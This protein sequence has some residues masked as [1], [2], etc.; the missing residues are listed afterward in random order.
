MRRRGVCPTVSMPASST[1]AVVVLATVALL[2]APEQSAPAGPDRLELV[3]T[4]TPIDLVSPVQRVVVL[5]AAGQ[6]LSTPSKGAPEFRA[7]LLL[8]GH[9]PA[10]A[11]LP[12]V[13]AT[14][15]AATGLATA[16]AGP[17]S[18]PAIT[19]PEPDPPTTTAPPSTAPPASPPPP[20]VPAAIEPA[21][22]PTPVE[23]AWLR[24]RADESVAMITYPWGELGYEI[25]FH[26]ARS[27]VR[28]QTFRTARRIEVYARPSDPASRTAFDLA[29]E[30]AHVFDFT[31]GTEAVHARWQ[32]A[33]GIEHRD[34]YGCNACPDLATPAGDFAESFAAWQM[35]GGPFGSRLGPPPDEAQRRLIAEL[36][37][38]LP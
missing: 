28:A 29:H 7:S 25:V 33:R 22:P 37:F 35:P 5:P 26:P 30:I 17:P 11:R 3:A 12:V 20:P 13:T 31:Y 21:P 24:R 1:L 2:L 10:V 16:D 34:W 27:G 23:P 19:A 36:T 6:P 8:P 9:A 18:Q 4:D 14:A 32:K 15:P 38:I